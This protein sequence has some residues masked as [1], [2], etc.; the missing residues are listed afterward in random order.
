[1]AQSTK[2]KTNRAS[3]KRSTAQRTPAPAPREQGPGAR[4]AG[5][6]V[7]LLLALCVAVS[8][9]NAEAVFLKLL[10]TALMGLC[11]YGYWL[12][13]VML[14]AAGLF[15]LLHRERRAAGRVLCALLTPLL[16]GSLLHLLL[17]KPAAGAALSAL[18]AGGQALTGGGVLCGGLA[19]LGKTYISEV[20][21]AILAAIGL[22]V[23]IFVML[24][25]TPAQV[26]EKARQRAAQRAQE[27]EGQPESPAEGASAES[28]EK[29]SH[30]RRNPQI[31]IPLDGEHEP[32]PESS[33]LHSEKK[34][35]FSRRRT[36]TPDEVLQPV[37]DVP[38][39]TA[40]PAEPEAASA[41]AQR[42]DP[43]P[44]EPVKAEPMA[45]PVDLEKTAQEVS[46]QIEQELS[47]P[48]EQYQYPPITLLDQGTAGSFT[49][50]GAEMRSNSKRLADT[51]RSFGVDA[52]P[53]EVVR[54]PSVTRYEFAQPQGVKL[55]KITNLSDDI[56][57]AAFEWP[58]CREKSPPWALR[59]PTGP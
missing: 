9:F 52:R 4:I 51:L 30:R 7:C 15:L 27:A 22:L 10:R 26:A 1:M 39:E 40:E 8:Y 17:A 21:Y 36:P 23:C 13:A 38:V 29:P 19:E 59:C 6:I 56:V 28:A 33:P 16:G 25:T 54:G 34:P 47:Q 42:H 24:R 31:D 46:R 55:S 20:V 49:E 50:A 45:E 11:G 57:W 41:P 43:E 32:I 58:R 2:K 18:W 48:E 12:W 53:G 37:K 3:G 14:L 35:F 44:A 5:G